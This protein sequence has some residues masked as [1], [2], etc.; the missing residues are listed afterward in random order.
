MFTDVLVL[1]ICFSLRCAIQWTQQFPRNEAI[2]AVPSSQKN[3]SHSQQ[4]KPSLTSQNGGYFQPVAL[5]GACSVSER[6]RFIKRFRIHSAVPRGLVEQ[7]TFTNSKP[8]RQKNKWQGAICLLQLTE[9]RAD[10]MYRQLDQL[11]IIRKCSGMCYTTSQRINAQIQ[12]VLDSLQESAFT[13]W[14][15]G[16]WLNE[17]KSLFFFFFFFLLWRKLQISK[18]RNKQIF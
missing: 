4:W 18:S 3:P 12:S 11:R 13:Q 14:S 1:F 10:F 9:P 17:W 2:C 16:A 6:A 5:G 8:C 15:L 7:M